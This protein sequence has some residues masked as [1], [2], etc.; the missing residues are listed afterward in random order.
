MTWRTGPNPGNSQLGCFLHG[1]FREE[2]DGK[3]DSRTRLCPRLSS[4]AMT[5]APKVA[6]LGSG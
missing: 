1:A 3:T 4:R 6:L 5:P 2:G